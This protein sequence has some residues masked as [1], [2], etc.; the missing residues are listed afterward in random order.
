MK[1]REQK[2]Y[3]CKSGEVKKQAEK[4]RKVFIQL[5]EDLWSV[6]TALGGKEA[7]LCYTMMLIKG[8][9]FEKQPEVGWTKPDKFGL[10]RPK[11]GTLQPDLMQYFTPKGSYAV[12]LHPELKEFKDWLKCPFWYSYKTQGGS[13]SITIGRLFA[14]TFVYWY[15]PKGPILLELPDVARAKREA[16]NNN[17]T[18]DNDVLDW[19]PPKGLKEILI[20]EWNLMAAKHK[21]KQKERR[22]RGENMPKL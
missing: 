17:Q 21:K 20:E 1:D 19:K 11:Q 10:S 5:V 16:I 12:T 14:D 6:I 15:D 2:Y 22:L 9:K 3:I 7:R 18:I 8:I 13:G 4:H